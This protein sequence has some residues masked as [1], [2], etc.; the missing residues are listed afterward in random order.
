M[1]SG[2][3]RGFRKSEFVART[4]FHSVSLGGG[5]GRGSMTRE[6]KSG[7]RMEKQLLR[8]RSQNQLMGANPPSGWDHLVI[9]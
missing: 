3:F 9:L 1:P 4:Q 8:V 6:E 5:D 7:T 2:C